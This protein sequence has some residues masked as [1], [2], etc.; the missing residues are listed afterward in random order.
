[1]ASRSLH[2]DLSDLLCT[3]KDTDFAAPKLC[4]SHCDFP[5]FPSE[6]SPITLLGTRAQIISRILLREFNS[7]P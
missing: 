5:G 6:T 2:P 1:M 3:L 7:Y 4:L